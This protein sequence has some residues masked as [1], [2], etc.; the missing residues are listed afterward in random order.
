MTKCIFVDIEE[1][2]NIDSL[3]EEELIFL[4]GEI[5]KQY[6]KKYCLKEDIR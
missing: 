2:S 4:K 3:T 1:V 5:D 6:W